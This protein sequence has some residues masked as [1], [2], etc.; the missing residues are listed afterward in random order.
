MKK[1]V[2]FLFLI[3]LFSCAVFNGKLKDPFE[4]KFQVTVLDID[5]VGDV[6]GILTISKKKDS[7]NS[8]VVYKEDGVETS[9]NIISSYAIDESTFIV[10]AFI[11]GNQ[12]DF[13]LNFENNDIIG[14][15]GGY[16]E[17]VGVR[18]E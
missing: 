9:M 2:C 14:M 13:E 5:G 18:I 11:D 15:V 16:Y 4:G 10:E 12:V 17:L 3:H 8:S 7:Y 1:L 6:P